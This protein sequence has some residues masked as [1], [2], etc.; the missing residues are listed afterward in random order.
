MNTILMT[1]SSTAKGGFIASKLT[2]AGYQ[3]YGVGQGGP[4]H[5]L[6]FR[7]LSTPNIDRCFSLAEREFGCPVRHLVLNARID[8]ALNPIDL[9][10]VADIA[11][12]LYCNLFSVLAFSVQF[13]KHQEKYFNLGD[14]LDRKIVVITQDDKTDL[15]KCVVNTAIAGLETYLDVTSIIPIDITIVKSGKTRE[16]TAKK[17]LAAFKV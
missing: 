15:I 10:P 14:D 7:Y 2:E 17:V 1:G 5:N 13:I 9:D 16:A 3:I 11:P 6:D 8:T 12:A 4:D